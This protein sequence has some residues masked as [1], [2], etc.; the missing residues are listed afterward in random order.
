[1]DSAR[2]AWVRSGLVVAEIALAGVLLVGAGL[3]TRSFVKLLDVELG[4]EPTRAVAARLD[5]PPT[6]SPEKAANL[7][8]EV[9]RRVSSLP[10]V[11]AAGLTDA[12][13]LERNRTWN[14][15]VPG[16][17]YRPGESRWC[18]STWSAPATFAR[19]GSVSSPAGLPRTR[20]R[21]ARTASR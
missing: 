17:I 9:V 15:M 13:P 8:R 5:L 20:R 4:F 18:S 3:L 6:T 16:K 21:D 12:L 10:G 2:Q 7:G 11:E 19:W 14:I 1:M